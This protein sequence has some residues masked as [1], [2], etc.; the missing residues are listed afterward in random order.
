MLVFLADV[1]LFTE[2]DEVD[3]RFGCKEKERVYHFDLA[4]PLG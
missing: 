3:N 1:V 2:V 4:V